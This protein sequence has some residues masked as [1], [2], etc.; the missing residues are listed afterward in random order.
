MNNYSFPQDITSPASEIEAA[1]R[2]F[3]DTRFPNPELHFSVTVPS[4]WRVIDVKDPVSTSKL[5]L[6]ALYKSVGEE[7]LAE[8][9][10]SFARF[11]HEISPNHWL[12]ILLS[13]L[14]EQIIER[15]EHVTEGGICPD[16]LTSRETEEGP[17][18]SRW[19]ALKD[20][21][22]EGG[23]NMILLQATTLAANYEN[24]AESFLLAIS[25]FKLLN[26]STWPL[27]ERLTTF[28]RRV[29]GDFLLAYPESWLIHEDP[30]NAADHLQ[31]TLIKKLSD[32]ITGKIFIA[33]VA[34]HKLQSPLEV[35]TSFTAKYKQMDMPV[36]IGQITE[37]PLFG[38]MLKVWAAT[39][40]ITPPVGNP[41]S[42]SV[43]IGSRPDAWF[44]I[45]LTTPSKED[46]FMLWAINQRALEIITLY[47]KTP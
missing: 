41:V 20:W 31:F 3:D 8:L 4:S 16:Y 30:D 5:N 17:V 18:I 27:A 23:A 46:N 33:A 6:I 13:S 42:N 47:F 37:A 24:L 39:V 44:Y 45:E 34:K 10:I 25:S 14:N 11:H 43:L 35:I 1:Y 32:D 21:A 15:K 12:E 7:P 9:E 36:E 26:P 38:G 40:V 2:T 29:P 19:L 22:Q 28:T